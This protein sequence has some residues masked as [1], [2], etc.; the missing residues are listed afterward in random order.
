MAAGS[1]PHGD[2]DAAQR[3][4]IMRACERLSLAYARAVDFRDYDEFVML[5]AENGVLD[6]GTPIVGRTAIAAAMQKRPDELR[7]RHVLTNH[8]VDV[9]NADEARGLAYLTLFR[10]V[11]EASLNA[12]PAPLSGVAAVGHYEDRFVREGERWLFARRKLH[13]A[14]RAQ[15]PQEDT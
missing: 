10:H 2:V 13:L 9:V 7:S 4:Q 12:G 8:F 6:V 11:G 5:F 15:T 1:W 3:E 14:F